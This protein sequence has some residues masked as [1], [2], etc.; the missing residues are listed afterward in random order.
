MIGSTFAAIIVVNGGA[1]QESVGIGCSLS[2]PLQMD[3]QIAKRFDLG[4]VADAND[5]GRVGA[6]DDGGAFNG[7]AGGSDPPSDKPGFSMKPPR[8]RNRPLRVPAIFGAAAAALA[9]ARI[10][11]LHRRQAFDAL[12]DELDARHAQRRA[13]A[14]DLLVALFEAVD[15]LID[16][17]RIERGRWHVDFDL[18]HLLAEAHADEPLDLSLVAKRLAALVDELIE[19]GVELACI[20]MIWTPA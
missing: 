11:P 13:L 12:G 5:D 18:M 16:R 20:D 9:G 15:E 3:E 10:W 6:L 4:A 2:Q 8:R 14:V 1:G 7:M 17:R 19:T